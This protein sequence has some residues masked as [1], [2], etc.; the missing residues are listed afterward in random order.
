[1]M[2]TNPL[3]GSLSWLL[4]VLPFLFKIFLWDFLLGSVVHSLNTSQCRV[5]LRQCERVFVC[6]LPLTQA[7]L[8]TP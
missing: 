3:S 8:C 6:V 7:S 1:M 5:S 2:V 4:P